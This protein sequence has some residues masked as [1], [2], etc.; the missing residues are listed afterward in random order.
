MLHWFFELRDHL[1]TEDTPEKSRLTT[2][3]PGNV[4]VYWYLLFDLL[5]FNVEH[6]DFEGQIHW[7]GSRENFKRG[8]RLVSSQRSACYPNHLVFSLLGISPLKNDLIFSQRFHICK[9]GDIKKKRYVLE[10]FW[11]VWLLVSWFVLFMSLP[12][13]KT[14]QDIK[15]KTTKMSGLTVPLWN[16]KRAPMYN[17]ALVCSLSKN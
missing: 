9:K 15:Q 2:C 6:S 16:I 14:C 13:W 12:R 10:T 17:L 7:P 5:S 1:Q 11:N 8:V 4:I 3:R